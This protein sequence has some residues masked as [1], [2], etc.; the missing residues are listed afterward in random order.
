MRDAILESIINP[1]H[2]ELHDNNCTWHTDSTR[3]N[4]GTLSARS[5]AEDQR[6][7]KSKVAGSNP[8]ER[9]LFLDQ[10]KLAE[11]ISIEVMRDCPN[12]IKEFIQSAY[13]AVKE[14]LA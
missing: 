2:E 13:R 1:S 7:P 10:V 5:S 4:C 8:A 9:D 14:S 3:C 11:R 6:P 12:H